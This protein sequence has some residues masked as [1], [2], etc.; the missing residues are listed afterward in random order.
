ML[1]IYLSLG[2]YSLLTCFEWPVIFVWFSSVVPT[3]R[4][5]ASAWL[6]VWLSLC[7]AI[8]HCLH[9]NMQAL[10]PYILRQTDLH[11][12]RWARLKCNSL[13]VTH[14]KGTS[15]SFWNGCKR[16]C[17]YHLVCEKWYFI[18]LLQW[19]GKGT[20]AWTSEDQNTAISSPILNVALSLHCGVENCRGDWLFKKVSYRCHCSFFLI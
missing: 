11:L 15:F 19:F 17:V 1:Y 7:L 3:L 9:S 6:C 4:L 18:F 8:L 2:R 5:G 13:V 20:C 12:C 16:K 14:L 10:W